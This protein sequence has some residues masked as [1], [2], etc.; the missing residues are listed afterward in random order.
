MT[1]TL[2]QLRKSPDLISS[3]PHGPNS[4]YLVIQDEE[5]ESYAFFG[6][7]MNRTIKDLMFPQNKEL[8]V[9]YGG[10]LMDSVFL[11]PA[12]NQPLSSNLYYAIDPNSKHIGYV[13]IQ[14]Y[15][16]LMT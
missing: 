7:I 9:H 2:S 6:L 10:D 3:L 11:I 4:G 8:N 13:F 1:R 14:I 12:L 15:I 16:L 5:S